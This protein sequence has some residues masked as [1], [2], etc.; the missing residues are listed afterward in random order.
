MGP[1]AGLDAVGKRNIT[2]PRR[3]S[4]P[5]RPAR[6]LVSQVVSK[7]LPSFHVLPSS[8]FIITSSFDT[9]NE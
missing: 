9:I 8:S 2:N 3:E 7:I 4:N 1:R 6:S 5:D